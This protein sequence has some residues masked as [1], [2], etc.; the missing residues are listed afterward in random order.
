MY[1]LVVTGQKQMC[2]LACAACESFQTCAAI[3]A[4]NFNKNESK[5]YKRMLN[6]KNGS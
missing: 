5:N 4:V 1:A 3:F 2:A 6:K